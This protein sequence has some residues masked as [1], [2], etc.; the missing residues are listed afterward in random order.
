MNERMIYSY[1]LIFRL[2][3][4][5]LWTSIYLTIILTGFSY[6]LA[7]KISLPLFPLIFLTVLFY[8]FYLL[9][10]L[11]YSLVL[12]SGLKL[13]KPVLPWFGIIPGKYLTADVYRKL[14]KSYIFLACLYILLNI[15]FIPDNLQILMFFY[16]VSLFIFRLYIYLRIFRIIKSEVRLKYE[17]FGISIFQTK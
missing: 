5:L 16:I 11:A 6:Y 4:S 15:L 10:G 8:L 7:K 3:G 9:W 14:E 1:K 2:R 12:R 17:P 13:I